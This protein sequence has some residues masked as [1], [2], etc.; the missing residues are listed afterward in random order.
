MNMLGLVGN[1]CGAVG[2]F[3]LARRIEDKVGRSV[4]FVLAAGNVVV[5]LLYLFA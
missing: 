2:M 4:C 5:I 3:F 1:V